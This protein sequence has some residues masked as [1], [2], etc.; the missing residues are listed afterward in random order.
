NYKNDES[1]GGTSGLNKIKCIT[2]DRA[3]RLW[4][5]T[6]RGG[7]C[8]FNKT[9]GSFTN[10][11]H[12][13]SNQQ[14]ISD[15]YVYSMLED[16]HGIFWVGTLNGLN[17][18]NRETKTFQRFKNDPSNEHSISNNTINTIYQTKDGSLWIGTDFGLNKYDYDKKSFTRILHENQDPLSISHS[19]VYALLEDKQGILWIGTRN[20]LNKFNRTDHSFEHFDVKDGLPNSIVMAIQEDEKGE[21]LISTKNGISRFNRNTR[22]FINY[23]LSDG[24]QGRQ[25]FP[26]ASCKAKDGKVF[27]GGTEGMNAFYPDRIQNNPYLPPVVITGI[28][29]AGEEIHFGKFIEDVKELVLPYHENSLT[30]DFVG[31]SFANPDENQYAYKLEGLDEDWKYS[32]NIRSAIYT[33]L[34][35]GSYLFRVKASNDDGLWNNKGATIRIIITPPFWKTLW[36][37]ALCALLT[38]ALIFAYIKN[39]ERSLRIE[40]KILEDKVQERTAEVTLQKEMLET[41]NKEIHDS[42]HYA[43]RI[44]EAILP[45]RED[46]VHAFPDSFILFKP[47]DIVSGDF[48]W[49]SEKN[50]KAIVTAADCTGHGVPGAF[51]SMIG[52]TLLNQIVNEKGVVK[53]DEIL[54]QLRENIMKSL[55]QTGAEGENKDGMDIAL[56]SFDLQTQELLFAGANNPLYIV[57]DGELI[58]IKGDKQPIGVY[59]GEPKPFTC[60][61]MQ[62]KKGDCVYIASDGYADQF[63]GS[64]GKK[65][66]YKQMKDL[67][68]SL[69]TQKM[70]EQRTALDQEIEKWR[71]T[72]EQVDDILV[73][74]FRV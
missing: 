58:E 7:V 69:H 13:P 32:G 59:L 9:K 73:I 54:M 42:I 50:G 20:G 43:K 64:N 15:D 70:T 44:Q 72:L 24:I 36:F 68:L 31:L 16:D 5:G 46:V 11:S 22:T 55:K 74:G 60:Q 49:F 61:R 17:I 2:S 21:L 6:Y 29:K 3:G 12:D 66:K 37:Y 39:R 40:K 34:R 18:F 57:S 14:S 41:Q 35:P 23:D 30:F 51:M 48:Y 45:A 4:L 52:N 38:L 25:F 8:E 63:G 33:N 1:E 10:Y 56:C 62:L 28:K 71:G 26:N 19:T 27:F 47:R 65:F 53:P 67:L